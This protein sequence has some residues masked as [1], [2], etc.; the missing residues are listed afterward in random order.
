MSLFISSLNS[1]S[2]GNCYYVGNQHEAVLIDAGLTC[3]ETEIRLLRSGL[4]ISKIKAIFIS[5]EHSDHT[6]GAE[7]IARKYQIPVYLS[8]GTY[9]GGRFQ[10]GNEFIRLLATYSPAHIGGLSVIAFPKK[11]DAS[12][13]QSFT[14]SGNGI[15]IG[16]FTDIGKVCKHLA[17]N[18]KLCNAAFLEANYDDEMLEKGGYPQILKDRIKSDHGHLSNRQAVELFIQH[19]GKALSH[20]LLSHLS[21]D[22]NSPDLVKELFNR[23]SQGTF[24]SIASRHVESPVYQITGNMDANTSGKLL[25]PTPK[26]VQ[27]KLF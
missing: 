17:Q 7:V 2:N 26:V 21:Q 20:L 1:G 9:K 10:L 12:E 13:P 22:N 23:H 5:H 4:D 8:P 18:F 24:V 14:V 19:K 11:H 25:I 16:I 27:M 6:R 15:T 3:R